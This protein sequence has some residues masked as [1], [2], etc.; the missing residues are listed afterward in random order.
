MR[1]TAALL[2]SPPLADVARG[3]ARPRGSGRRPG[4]RPVDP[5]APR[6]RPA[7]LRHGCDG[8]RRRPEHAAVDQF[9]RV[10]GVRG[11]RVADTSILPDAPTG[12]PPSPPS[13]SVRSSPTPC[14]ADSL[15]QERRKSARPSTSL[16]TSPA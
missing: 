16:S 1:V 9:G 10:H 6:H 12:G 11:L 3:Q 2:E 8:S 15:R 4:P 5:R 7:H 14:G 13:S